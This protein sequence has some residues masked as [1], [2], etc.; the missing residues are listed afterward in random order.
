MLACLLDQSGCL[1]TGGDGADTFNCSTA[2]GLLMAAVGGITIA[3]VSLSFVSSRKQRFE[4]AHDSESIHLHVASKITTT[5]STF[6]LTLFKNNKTFS[7]SE[8]ICCIRFISPSPS[9]LLRSSMAIGRRQATLVQL[10]SLKLLV[11]TSNWMQRQP[12]RSLKVVVLA[13]CLHKCSIQQ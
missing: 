12:P 8:S 1:G 7:S 9:P 13:F 4:Y 2:S 10:I 5:F 6:T 3:K 11:P